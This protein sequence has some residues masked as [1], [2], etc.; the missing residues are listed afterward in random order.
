MPLLIT[1]ARSTCG[2]TVA[3]LIECHFCYIDSIAI[4]IWLYGIAN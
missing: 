2:C 4:T 1:D 3:E